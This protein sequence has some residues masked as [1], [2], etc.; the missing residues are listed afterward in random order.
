MTKQDIK[1][2]DGMEDL[3]RS[4][5]LFPMGIVMKL[6]GLTARQIRYYETHHLVSPERTKGHQRLFSLND[7]DRL[8]E[9]K[10]LIDQG[11][12]IA[13]IQAV[14]GGQAAPP[15]TESRQ[16]REQRLERERLTEADVHE[17]LETYLASRGASSLN[18]ALPL[19][20]LSRFLRS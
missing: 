11:L 4:V 3:R 18:E 12:N 6:T 13:G 9:I 5:A 2:G 16:K 15:A 8:L 14:L 20:E 19:G 1:V 10:K 7:I 17:M